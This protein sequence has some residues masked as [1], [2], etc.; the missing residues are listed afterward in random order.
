VSELSAFGFDQVRER[1]A[2]ARAHGDL[3]AAYRACLWS[4]TASRVLLEIG[5]GA[6][7]DGDALYRTASDIDWSSHFGV[8]NSFSVDATVLDN[9]AFRQPHF[10][11]LRVKD[12]IVDQLRER[13]GS[14]PTVDT[15]QPDI[16]L[17]VLVRRREAVLSLDLS[18][19]PLHRRGYRL[20][21]GAAP[22]RE[23]LA[24]ALLLRCRWPQIA[25]RGGAFVDLMC[26]AGTL[27]IEAAQIAG[28]IAPGLQRRRWGFSAWAGHD[29]ALWARLHEEA[30]ERRAVGVSGLPPLFG[31]D[32]SG[33]ALRLALANLVR[34]GLADHVRLDQRRIER[35]GYPV[36]P[37]A[38]QASGLVMANPPYG[39]RLGLDD[40]LPALY[41]A[42]GDRLRSE[43]T[44]WHA[45]VFTGNPPLGRALGIEANRT[46]RYL[47]GPIDCR[48]LMFD[49]VPAAATVAAAPEAVGQGVDPW[50]DA[51]ER[52][53]AEAADAEAR[54]HAAEAPPELT[55][56]GARELANR[57]RKNLRRL[58]R[59]RSRESVSCYRLYDSDLP[60]YRVAVDVYSTR[61]HGV[62][63]HV[64]E[65][66]APASVDAQRARARLGHAIDAVR[67]VLELPSAHVH[68]KRRRRQRGTKAQYERHSQQGRFFEVGEG[69]M[70]FLV[71]LDDYLDTGLFLD[72]RPVRAMIRALA[73]GRRFLNLF[74]YT[75]TATVAAALGGARQTVTVDLSRTYLDW[76]DRNIAL[77]VTDTSEHRT[78]RADVMAWIKEAARGAPMF[79][80]IFV[81]PPSFSTSKRMAGTFDVQRDHVFL[82]KTCLRLLTPDGVLLFS[83]NLRRFELDA[84]A[85]AGLATVED[86]SAA[87]IPQ[88]F[89]RR[90]DVHHCWRLTHHRG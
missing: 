28:D 42:L 24:A 72:H 89:A 18:G 45:G 76:A 19:E 88:D 33:D 10:A 74:A 65:Y 4:R 14:R 8:D 52:A 13:H 34:A 67:V 21:Q 16:R 86:V 37:A 64:Q 50:A 70:R 63:A 39:E 57:L 73:P 81:D 46:A 25:G 27:L 40:D 32:A 68:V 83:N 2:G 85:L 79:D 75:G 62:H 29:P 6:A 82:L 26:G 43:F 56:A 69:D 3:A 53:R 20:E 23:T 9:S 1:S 7:A 61:Q 47:N 90:P 49:A 58:S 84:A 31:F 12:A 78:V 54:Q 38:G 22:L 71:N 51:A 11:A 41:A 66:E 87:T 77:N 55:E 35:G 5:T 15:Q 44:G 60:E 36:P 30:V 59:W 80:L 48:L 17:R